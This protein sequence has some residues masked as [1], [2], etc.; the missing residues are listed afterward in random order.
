MRAYALLVPHTR[1]ASPSPG[2]CCCRTHPP[3]PPQAVKAAIA[4]LNETQPG[5][6]AKTLAEAGVLDSLL[7]YHVTEGA[8]LTAD[9]LKD[10]MTLTM[11]NKEKT[12]IVM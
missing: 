1:P 12:T 8:A 2:A 9:R 5:I 10:N 7:Q 4:A 6:D 11:L 3:P